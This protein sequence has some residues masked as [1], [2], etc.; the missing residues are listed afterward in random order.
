MNRGALSLARKHVGTIADLADKLKIDRTYC[1]RILSGE[2]TPG[3]STRVKAR[4]IFRIPLDAWV[5]TRVGKSKKTT[6]RASQKPQYFQG[7]NA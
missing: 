5:P 1:G 3:I 7:A 6:R 4:E 2:R